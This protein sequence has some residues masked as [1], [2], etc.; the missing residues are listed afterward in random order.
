[1]ICPNCKN[2][3]QANTTRCEWCGFEL[4]RELNTSSDPIIHVDTT[5]SNSIN[6]DN[7]KTD[8]KLSKNKLYF[9]MGISVLL[10]IILSS[11]IIFENENREYNNNNMQEY[12]L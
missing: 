3:I 1:M 7:K 10:I 8:S 5:I 2:P 11:Y 6:S 9:L 4:V 12:V